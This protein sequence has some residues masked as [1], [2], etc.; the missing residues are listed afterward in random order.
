MGWRLYPGV[1]QDPGPQPGPAFLESKGTVRLAN[2]QSP[3]AAPLRHK[4]VGVLPL[5]ST[6]MCDDDDDLEGVPFLAL[7]S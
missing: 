1:R 7:W 2:R 5:R 3:Q 4:A 6:T